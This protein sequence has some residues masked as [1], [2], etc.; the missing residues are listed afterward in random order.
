MRLIAIHQGRQVEFNSPFASDLEAADKAIQDNSSSFAMGIA[1]VVKEGK[2]FSPNQRYWLHKVAAETVMNQNNVGT[3]L[4]RLFQRISIERGKSYPS[5]T[6]EFE[7]VGQVRFR[8]STKG[9]FAGSILVTTA[10]ANW[11]DRK[12]YGYIS[13]AGVWVK[14]NSIPEVDKLVQDFS[15]DPLGYADK[16]GQKTGRCAL[17]GRAL[18]AKD[19]V[20]K[21]IG[22]VCAKA[23][24]GNLVAA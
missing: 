10:E 4:I 21:G 9:S 17:C 6:F 20:Y 23:W 18:T 1:K 3:N 19:S 12:M 16:Y 24:R 15:E 7:G 13:K 22:P 2:S 11:Q 14:R 5:A 8:Y